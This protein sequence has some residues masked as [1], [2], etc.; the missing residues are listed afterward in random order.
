M[1]DEQGG[2]GFRLWLL[3]AA[4]FMALA[5]AGLSF[6][7]EASS[8]SPFLSSFSSFRGRLDVQKETLLAEAQREGEDYKSLTLSSSFLRDCPQVGAKFEPS[9]RGQGPFFFGCYAKE[10]LLV[11]KERQREQSSS[12]SLSWLRNRTSEEDVLLHFSPGPSPG[13][14][15]PQ[16]PQGCSRCSLGLW[17]YPL[18]LSPAPTV[19]LIHWQLFHV[20]FD[21]LFFLRALRCAYSNAT[22]IVNTLDK[23]L[24]SHDVTKPTGLLD[25]AVAYVGLQRI[26]TPVACSDDGRE[27]CHTYHFSKQVPA[28]LCHDLYK[29]QQDCAS[30]KSLETAIQSK[31]AYTGVFS[32][33]HKT[34]DTMTERWS[35]RRAWF[36]DQIRDKDVVLDLGAGSMALAR[37]LEQ[38]QQAGKGKISSFKYFPVDIFDRG[39]KAMSVC[40]FNLWEYPLTLSPSPTVI[41]AQGVFEFVFDKL[42][43]WKALHCAYP[44]AR[45]LFS[46]TMGG[47][48]NHNWPAPLT[49]ELLALAVRDLG[50]ELITGPTYCLKSPPEYCYE[51]N[52]SKS[53][54]KLCDWK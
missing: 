48:T 9:S 51:Y 47:N 38:L 20:V 52:F 34:S 41:V 13:P 7:L 54:Q 22:L 30:R 44:S 43:L 29:P 16:G 36:V 19:I 6:L 46:T 15:G 31:S 5:L 28:R 53:P 23:D 39:N 18:T 42:A 50:W 11:S 4:S 37:D 33:L 32:T 49:P 8:F 3:A 21:R 45:L 2:T 24:T 12:A 25:Q 27:R 26:G 1:V 17:E 35:M 14:Q 40:N 10:D